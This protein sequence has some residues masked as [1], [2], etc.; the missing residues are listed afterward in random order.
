[1]TLLAC[2]FCRELFPKGEAADCPVCGMK[3]TPADKLPASAEAEAEGF[4]DPPE[5]EPLPATYMGRG[6]GTLVALALLGLVLFFLPWLDLTSPYDARLSGFDLG[7]RVGW[8]WAAG[9]AWFVLVPTVLSRRSVMQMRGARVAAAFLA[10]I[11]A[12]TATIL[13]ARPP[14]GG[15]VP[16]HFSYDG[17]LV[18]TLAVSV[19][20]VLVAA[21]RFGGRTDDLP[22]RT[23]RTVGETLH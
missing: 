20:G 15:L 9:V 2:P 7:R 3:L 17:A 13:L 19:V 23:N 12:S 4:A 16:V 22:T 10:G 21:F 11:P 8:P 6:R 18:A 1:M 5:Y 14:K